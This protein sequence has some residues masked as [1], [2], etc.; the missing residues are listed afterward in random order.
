MRRLYISIK[1]LLDIII[2]TVALL[3]LIPLLIVIGL[4]IKFEDHGPIFYVSKRVGKG[5]EPIK[6]YKFRSMT[7]DAEKNI[8]KLLKYN[9]RNDGPLFKM[10]NDPRIT[11][12]GKIL[13]KYSLD[14][15]PQLF[16]VLK[17]DM[18]IV[19]PRPHL[20]KEVEAYQ[21]TDYLRLE[22]MPGIVCLPQIYGRNYISFREWVDY[23]LQ[24]RKNWSVLLDLKI[25][26]KT[27]NLILA[28]FFVKGNHG[29]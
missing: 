12:V 26:I 13:R 10:K 27:V 8:K 23:D 17:G 2:S 22:C 19:G 14:E 3:C 15:V 20:S 9:E 1:R 25:M 11:K 4:A 28:S 24:Y 5:G 7:V 29:F 6:F 21:G 18:S 16:N